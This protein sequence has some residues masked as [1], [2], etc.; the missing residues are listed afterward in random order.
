VIDKVQADAV[1]KAYPKAEM[2]A[3]L[4]KNASHGYYKTK[5]A[6]RERAAELS[7]ILDFIQNLGGVVRVE[8]EDVTAI[9]KAI[10][11]HEKNGA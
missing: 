10:A 6:H 7:G 1:S 4:A 8:N 5:R 2:L 3:V 11:L 9:S